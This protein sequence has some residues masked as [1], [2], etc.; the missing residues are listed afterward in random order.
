MMTKTG[1]QRLGPLSLT[2]LT[3]LLEKTS[4]PKDK[5]KIANR[6]KILKKKL[7]V[8]K[9]KVVENFKPC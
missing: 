7:H 1:K 3:E 4:R 2:Q 8:G 9:Y 6:V 5:S